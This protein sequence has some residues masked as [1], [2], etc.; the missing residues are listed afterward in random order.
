M[1]KTHYKKLRNPN[2]LGTWDLP[3]G[4]DLVTTI[5][6]VENQEVFNPKDNSKEEVVVVELK[7]VKPLIANATNCKNIAQ[8]CKS[9]Y[10]EDWIG[11]PIAIYATKVKAFGDVVEAVRVRPNPPVVRICKCE[12]CGADI[13]PYKSMSS[14]DM[15]AYTR[16]NYGKALCATCATAAKKQKEGGGEK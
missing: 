13:Q 6:K 3:Q 16:K 8:A 12:Q 2:F 1:E 4:K 5:T 11:K 15:A 10:V 9:D 14:E 7:G